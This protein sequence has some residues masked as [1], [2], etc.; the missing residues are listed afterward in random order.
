MGE[1]MHIKVTCKKCG[2]FIGF[3]D[4]KRGPW[5]DDEDCEHGSKCPMFAALEK[6]KPIERPLHQCGNRHTFAAG[7]EDSG[8]GSYYTHAMT[9]NDQ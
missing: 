6:F 9:A 2:R 4:G 7:D 1:M 8:H 5:M 3:I